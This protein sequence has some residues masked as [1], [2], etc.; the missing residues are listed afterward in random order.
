MLASSFDPSA[1]LAFAGIAIGV[2]LAFNYAYDV[3][4]YHRAQ[5][6]ETENCLPPKYPT[7]IPYL[8]NIVPFLWNTPSFL[9]RTTSYGGQLGSSRINVGPHWDVYLFQDR[10]T[11]M[12][13]WKNSTI[14]CAGRVHVWACKYLFGMPD[15]FLSLYAA[16][17]SGPFAKPYPGSNVPPH[18]RVHRLMNEG[19][20]K[21]LTGSGFDPTLQ[22]FRKA[23]VLQ[24]PATL[25]TTR[26]SEGSEWIEIP[27]FRK[28]IHNTVGTSLVQAVFG[29]SLL[30][31]NPTFMDDLYEFDQVLPLLSKGLPSFIMPQPYAIRRRLRDNFK[32]WYAY[33]RKHFT[34]SAISED[35]DGDP[36]W[37]SNWMR[38]RQKT[39]D[40]I[41][42]DDVLAAG[43]LGVAWASIANVVSAS[44]M[45]LVH[46]AKTQN[47]PNRVRN[48]V[49]S[50]FGN[51]PLEDINLRQLSK[52]PL[53]SSIYAE[54]LRL[55]VKSFTVVSSPVQDINLGKFRLPKNSMGL[56]NAH[57]S[58]M[59]ES[60]WNTKDGLHPLNSFW[61]ERF[62][63]DPN[64]PSSG[65]TRFTR[66]DNA[67]RDDAAGNPNA[68]YYSMKG[69][70]GSWIPY[71]GG[72]LICP[73]RFLAK[74]VMILACALLTSEFEM[75][76]LTK[77][78]LFSSKWFGFGAEIPKHA[79]AVRIRRRVQ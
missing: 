71:G 20:E 75:E 53:L 9:Q 56:V 2:G 44:T 21:A 43:D 33:A 78:I 1:L 34:E 31:V 38:Q 22:R 36:F 12:Q 46:V 66:Q 62:L 35:G 54:T 27:D 67:I 18:L 8:G 68:P 37:G 4:E 73:G 50:A 7:L 59:D 52:N 65:P 55:H 11:V 26:V 61:A 51:Q 57:V 79:I 42:D 76:V 58:H 6:N 77:E 32:R 64:D 28:F 16:D 24:F 72:H 13:L 15:K 60:F 29:P 41:Q 3:I 40:L 30:H 74:N 49:T 69:L 5:G 47:L 70:E 45:V 25:N 23:F 39:L 10:E 48:E 63:T 17:N 19:I 14:M